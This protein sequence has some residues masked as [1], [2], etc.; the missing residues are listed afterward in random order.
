M[1]GAAPTYY[2]SPRFQRL[3]QRR[4]MTVM[5]GPYHGIGKSKRDGSPGP[6]LAKISSP[7]PNRGRPRQQ[8]GASHLPLFR[9][10]PCFCLP[11]T[12]VT[13]WSCCTPASG[14]L[15]Q[16]N[17]PP[18]GRHGITLRVSVPWLVVALDS[19]SLLLFYSSLPPGPGNFNMRNLATR[20]PESV[21]RVNDCHRPQ[22]PIYT[23][24][25]SVLFA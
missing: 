21:L 14:Q 4:V 8:D 24:P 20:A 18:A 25:M 22:R 1:L 5:S 15:S 13:L 10:D 2:T 9:S 11:A 17:S 19:V 16:M 23:S 12:T 7:P 3:R 6:E